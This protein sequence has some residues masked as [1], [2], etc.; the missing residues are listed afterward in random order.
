MDQLA[1]FRDLQAEIEGTDTADLHSH[2]H[3]AAPGAR[4]LRHLVS[5]HFLQN[6]LR[7]AGVPE[8]VYKEPDPEIRFR[9]L[10]PWFAKIANVGTSYSLR[11]IL[12]DLYGMKEEVLGPDNA[13]RLA[14][15]VAE[16]AEDAEWPREVLKKRARLARVFISYQLES[17]GKDDGW[18]QITGDAPE[19]ARYHDLFLLA[20]EAGFV[21]DQRVLA[22]LRPYGRR[23]WPPA[24]SA[25]AWMD[26]HWAFIGPEQ[27]KRLKSLMVW[28]NVRLR[29]FPGQLEEVAPLAEAAWRRGVEAGGAALDPEDGLAIRMYGLY[30]MIA[31]ARETGLP[32]QVFLGSAIQG[33][34]WGEWGGWQASHA[35]YDPLAAREMGLVAGANPDVRFDW[36]QGCANNGQEMS[37]MA[38]MRPNVGLC[39]VWWHCMYPAYL[40][41]II[42]ERLDAAP[43]TKTCLFFSDAYMAEWCYGKRRLVE[44]EFAYVLAERVAY[45]YLTRQDASRVIQAWM[46]D[47]PARVYGVEELG[48]GGR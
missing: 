32:L 4:S 14:G 12:Q 48:Q 42:A 13:D 33:G 41:R 7:A 43:L 2:L 23:R 30:T 40:R 11:R 8:A 26:R 44:R 34:E 3:W 18:G 36:L 37:I 31:H 24:A 1:L 19:A 5:Y 9:G 27:K 45:G 21:S 47:N 25:G 38:K 46:R 22:H 20:G 29:H 28:V 17:G 15:Q 6:E 39:G 16:R 10:L 35:D